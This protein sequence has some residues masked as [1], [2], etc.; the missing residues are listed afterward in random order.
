M[1][2]LL[3]LFAR[4]GVRVVLNGHEHNFQ[5]S[6]HDGI[7]YFVSGAGSKLDRGRPDRFDDAHTV[8]WSNHAHFLLVTIAGSTMTVRVVG[9]LDDVQAT[10]LR[11]VP[12]YTPAGS[13]VTGP[14]VLR[15]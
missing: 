6:R 10:E 11:D 5:H 3:P 7:D 2:A 9:E 4:A 14:I 1:E 13:E 15:L 12:R 8:S